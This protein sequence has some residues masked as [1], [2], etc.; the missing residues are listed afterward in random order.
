MTDLDEYYQKYQQLLSEHSLKSVSEFDTDKLNFSRLQQ[1]FIDNELSGLDSA[2]RSRV[3]D[4]ILNSG[5]LTRLLEQEDITEILVTDVDQ[6]WIEKSGQL[7]QWH[8]KFF[9]NDSYI[10]F[11]D[12][13]C[14]EA[15]CFF[16]L[17]N[18][19]VNASWKNFRVHIIA[20]PL[21]RSLPQLSL[22]RTA[23]SNWTLYKLKELGWCDDSALS[24]L[25]NIVLNKKNSLIIGA[26]STGKTSA[27]NAMI[28]EAGT[29][30]RI[31]CIEDT[32]E[33]QLPNKISS[34]LLTR[35]SSESFLKNFYMQ[36]LLKESLRMRPD[37]IILGEVRGAE[38]KDL[39][40]AFATGHRGGMAT[41]HA[42]DPRQALIRLEMLI[43]LGAPQWSVQ[44][45]RHLI[46]LSLDNI[47]LIRK[48]ASRR[49]LSGVYEITS[50]EDSG[51]CLET[52]Y[53]KS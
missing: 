33:I 36:D 46:R 30:E 41:L 20:P 22:R 10:S 31:I 21:A 52:L 32:D 53:E 27:L 19:I 15:K 26:T 1:N 13:L 7:L 40:L 39:L 24:I 8:D 25:K 44:A 9:S 17:K 35:V 11:L 14:L 34:K 3:M 45:I 18:P 16:D 23:N 6:I 4:E 29:E 47:I 42:D 48:S 12:R 2:N 5:P 38:A 50:L 49:Y 28:H 37:R 51:F 43:Q